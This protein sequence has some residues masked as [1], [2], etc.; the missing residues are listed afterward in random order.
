M[1]YKG[2][3]LLPI[4]RKYNALSRQRNSVCVYISCVF[5]KHLAAG[6]TS[7]HLSPSRYLFNLSSYVGG[8]LA[9]YVE[10][11]LKLFVHLMT[12]FFHTETSLFAAVTRLFAQIL[13]DYP[14]FVISIS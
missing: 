10:I 2:L 5:L 1:Y 11:N 4:R 6:E 14:H 9:S 7:W 8:S 12:S 3:Q 13:L